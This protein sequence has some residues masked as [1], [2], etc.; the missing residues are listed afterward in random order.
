MIELDIVELGIM[1]MDA[2]ILPSYKTN[3]ACHH[4][5]FVYVTWIKYYNW[6]VQWGSVDKNRTDMS[7]Y[8]SPSDITSQMIADRSF[9][10]EAKYFPLCENCTYQ[11]SSSCASNICQNIYRKKKIKSE[12]RC[13]YM[14]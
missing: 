2:D 7:S 4:I 5:L 13:L 8:V 9:D 14:P 12:H 6:Y 11:T 1:L 3:S 10:A